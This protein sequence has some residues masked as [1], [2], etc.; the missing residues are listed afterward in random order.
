[1]KKTSSKQNPLVELTTGKLSAQKSEAQVESF[2]KFMPNKERNK[3]YSSV[4]P[5]RGGRKGN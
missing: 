1:M 2:R 4:G 5:S 3:N